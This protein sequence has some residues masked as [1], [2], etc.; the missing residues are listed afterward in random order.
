MVIRMRHTRAH[1]ANRRSHHALKAQHLTTCECGNPR[2][3]HRACPAC[4]RYNGRVVVDVAGKLAAR[5]AK[6]AKKE[7]A[8]SEAQK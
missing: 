5:Q 2:V 8:K 3:S 4:G 6:A 7:G 1:T